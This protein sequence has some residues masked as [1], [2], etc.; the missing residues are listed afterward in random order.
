MRKMTKKNKIAAVA[1]SATLLAAGGG[2]A[3]AYWSTTGS[4]GGSASASSGTTKSTIAITATFADGLTP[5]ATED[6]TYTAT[7]PNSSSTTVTLDN[8]VVSADN[9]CDATWFTASVPTN[10]TSIAAGATQTLGTGKLVF[11]DTPGNQDLCKGAKI[12]VSVTSH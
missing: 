5:G 7:N 8:A 3:Y 12:T 9:G 11:A 1:L 10:T 4:G 6:I 2:A